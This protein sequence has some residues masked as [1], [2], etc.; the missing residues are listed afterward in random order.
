LID[1]HSGNIPPRL[2][3]ARIMAETTTGNPKATARAQNWCC[4]RSGGQCVDNIYGSEKGLLMVNPCNQRKYGLT[5]SSVF[6][7]E[8]NIRVGC[9]IWN[10][11]A[12]SFFKGAGFDPVWAWL[13]TA[14]G[15]GAAKRLR[16]LA[17]GYSTGSLRAVAANTALMTASKGYWGSQSPEKVS[18][19]V[20]S[21]ISAVQVAR[22]GGGFGLVLAVAGI[23][24]LIYR[25]RS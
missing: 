18:H 14:V 12:A 21:A 19:R 8:T 24:Y 16:E 4:K 15:P 22:I 6:D 2:V 3:A 9:D 20:G 17:G 23:A 11:W 1:K 25:W 13:V 7:P 5:S 10:K